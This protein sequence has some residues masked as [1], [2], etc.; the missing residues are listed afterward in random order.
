MDYLAL[1]SCGLGIISLCLFSGAVIPWI[2][3]LELV[4][5]AEPYAYG[6]CLNMLTYNGFSSRPG[7]VIWVHDNIR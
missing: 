6:K 4:C 5:L 3:S 2:G 7:C 1:V